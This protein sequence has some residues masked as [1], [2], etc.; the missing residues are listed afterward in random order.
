MKSHPA[1]Q[2]AAS[3]SLVAVG[4]AR[5]S[6]EDMSNVPR[7]PALAVAQVLLTATVADEPMAVPRNSP[8][9]VEHEREG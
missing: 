2:L 6:S 9:P 1:S 4:C 3:S 5:H 8:R 7:K